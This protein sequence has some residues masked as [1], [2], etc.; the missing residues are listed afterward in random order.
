M[1]ICRGA[2][3]VFFLFAVSFLFG[4]G[5]AGALAKTLP[6]STAIGSHK[7]APPVNSSPES[8]SATSCPPGAILTPDAVLGNVCR[9]TKT[10][11]KIAPANAEGTCPAGYRLM[12]E[13][14]EPYCSSNVAGT[15]EQPT[16]D[17]RLN[18]SPGCPEGQAPIIDFHG[19]M[20][21]EVNPQMSPYA[22]FDPKT[23]CPIGTYPGNSNGFRGCIKR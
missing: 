1:R 18:Q 16:H 7:A 10:G 20:A 4:L 13:A 2:T 21:C 15:P 3:G 12:K 17:A 23:D 19:A 22:T 6:S 5:S 9:I 8:Q 11:V 14:S